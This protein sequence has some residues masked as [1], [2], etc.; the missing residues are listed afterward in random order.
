MEVIGDPQ[1]R[2]SRALGADGELDELARTE[3]LAR[4]EQSD[5][6][7]ESATRIALLA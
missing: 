3:L 6:H 2:E 4:Q 1:A 5:A 7:T